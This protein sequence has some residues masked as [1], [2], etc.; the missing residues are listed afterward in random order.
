MRAYFAF[1]SDARY[2]RINVSIAA[3]AKSVAALTLV[4]RVDAASV[5]STTPSHAWHDST[6]VTAGPFGLY[7]CESHRL[8]TFT[9]FHSR[10]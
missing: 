1:S 4:G 8:Q 5:A 9:G 7:V 6:H 2:S 3:T 10:T